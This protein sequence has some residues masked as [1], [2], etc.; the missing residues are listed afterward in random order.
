MRFGYA[1]PPTK[2]IRLAILIGVTLD[3]QRHGYA[4]CLIDALGHPLDWRLLG[5]AVATVAGGA[6]K[7]LGV[8]LLLQAHL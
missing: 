7:M 2:V 8:W 6:A 5:S 1:S 4:W 3:S